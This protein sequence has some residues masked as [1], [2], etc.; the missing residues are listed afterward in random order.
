MDS[1]FARS[2]LE[3]ALAEIPWGYKQ[4]SILPPSKYKSNRSA[5]AELEL[6]CGRTVEIQCSQ[7][8]W[9]ML[10]DP[11]GQIPVQSLSSSS[12]SCIS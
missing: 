3:Q 6:L 2:E 5:T 11:Q 9:K 12:N 10:Q 1:S 7:D 4:S 8:G